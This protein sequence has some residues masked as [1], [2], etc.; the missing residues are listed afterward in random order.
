MQVFMG[1]NDCMAD[2]PMRTTSELRCPFLDCRSKK[3]ATVGY[4]PSA[5][6]AGKTEERFDERL[7]QCQKCERKFLYLGDL[8]LNNNQ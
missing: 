1:G 8:S 5:T 6:S 3:V 2:E 4:D 7:F